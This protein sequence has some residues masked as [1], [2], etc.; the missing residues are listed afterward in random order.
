LLNDFTYYLFNAIR[1]QKADEIKKLIEE[2]QLEKPADQDEK[3]FNNV[4][5]SRYLYNWI[6][7][8]DTAPSRLIDEQ[9][10]DTA[11][12]QSVIC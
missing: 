3:Y 6:F 2:Y 5:I 7:D 12:K 11:V 4:V 9:V 1:E 8:S 10:I